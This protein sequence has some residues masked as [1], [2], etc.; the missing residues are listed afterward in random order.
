MLPKARTY[1]HLLQRD[2]IAAAELLGVPP[3]P[4]APYFH[5]TC[6]SAGEHEPLA[7]TA[8]PVQHQQ[9]SRGGWGGVPRQGSLRRVSI[10]TARWPRPPAAPASSAALPVAPQ[11]RPRSGTHPGSPKP[12]RGTSHRIVKQDRCSFPWRKR[13]YRSPFLQRFF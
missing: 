13:P 10:S 3:C 12:P 5:T 7:F 1:V 11:G 6:T 4:P 9:S 2:A 8:A